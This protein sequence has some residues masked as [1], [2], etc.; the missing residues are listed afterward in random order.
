MCV[1]FTQEK[2][3]SMMSTRVQIEP[4]TSWL[5][6]LLVSARVQNLTL[7]K[8]VANAY[9][10]NRFDITRNVDIFHLALKI[11]FV[12]L[13]LVSVAVSYIVVWHLCTFSFC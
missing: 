2:Y 5:Q 12:L 4:Y 11:L 1:H 13:S 7:H 9:G 8:M 6:M 10:L 3:Y